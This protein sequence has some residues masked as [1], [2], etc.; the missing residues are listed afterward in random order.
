MLSLCGCNLK[1]NRKLENADFSKVNYETPNYNNYYSY[2]CSFAVSDDL[3]FYTKIS[4]LNSRIFAYQNGE[5]ISIISEK[6][7]KNQYLNHD[8]F[9][10]GNDLYFSTYSLESEFSGSYLYK[11]NLTDKKYEQIFTLDEETNYWKIAKDHIVYIKYYDGDE[12]FDSLYCYNIPNK[13]EILISKEIEDFSI[14]NGKVQYITKDNGYTLNEY[15]FTNNKSKVLGNFKGYSS[16]EYIQYN[17][18]PSG[19]TMIP[20]TANSYSTT[21]EFSFY[22]KDT[23]T[24][25]KL[26]LPEN[27]CELIACDKYAYAICYT[28]KEDNSEIDYIDY[29]GDTYS[30]YRINLLNGDFRYLDVEIDYTSSIFV[31]TDD[32]L[33]ISTDTVSFLSDKTKVIKYDLNTNKIE[34]LL[35]Y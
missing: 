6:D 8:I 5:K 31:N 24:V 20:N 11:Y 18:T 9:L 23:N 28:E 1:R 21:S 29:E 16:K 26:K 32:E 35:S 14:V 17:F 7:F 22:N 4:D 25:S 34:E 12:G 2:N 19:I 3:Y 13:K 10:Y 30:L 15:D 33:Y 27:L